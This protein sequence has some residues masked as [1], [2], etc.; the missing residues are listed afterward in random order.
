MLIL[1]LR[2]MFLF[3]THVFFL[4]FISFHFIFSVDHPHLLGVLKQ[5]AN[6]IW[7]IA[8]ILIIWLLRWALVPKIPHSLWSS[9]DPF[10]VVTIHKFHIVLWMC[11]FFF[12]LS[13]G[14]Q[15]I[16]NLT[17][18]ESIIIPILVRWPHF[19]LKLVVQIEYDCDKMSS[20][21]LPL[22]IPTHNFTLQH[23]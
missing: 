7:L 8:H 11:F 5:I 12:D 16:S 19:Y 21:T 1:L 15:G 13:L 23:I 17:N 22:K 2:K 20:L 14:L 4:T 9:F 3:T 18:H 10:F 6:F